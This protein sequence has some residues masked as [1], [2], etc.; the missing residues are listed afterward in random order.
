MRYTSFRLVKYAQYDTTAITAKFSGLRSNQNARLV[1]RDTHDCL[2]T[3]YAVCG[4]MA[5]HWIKAVG[6]W[7]LITC[8]N[9]YANTCANHVLSIHFNLI[10]Y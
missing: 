1:H 6:T 9:L 3:C 4:W 8:Q 7:M 2:W 5:R 10:L